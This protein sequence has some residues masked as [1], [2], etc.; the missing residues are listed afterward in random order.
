MSEQLR[1]LDERTDFRDPLRE[2]VTIRESRRA[3]RLILQV[4]PPHTL[5]VVVPKGTRPHAVEAFVREN[6]RWIEQAR[7]ELAERF[8]GERA[9]LPS[10]VD[11]AA[12]GRATSITYTSPGEGATDNA[13]A[14]TSR[15]PHVRAAGEGLIVASAD[16]S[17]RQARRMLRDWLL[18]EAR[19]HLEPWLWRE[20]ERVGVRP[21]RV[22][23][24]LQRTRW[25][26][27]SARGTI[28]LN[29]A[30]LLLEPPLVRYL[31][32]HELCH[33]RRMSHSAR[34][35]RDV[36]RFEPDYRSLD[37]ALAD[38]WTCIPLWLMQAGRDGRGAA[39]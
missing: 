21:S 1:L 35:W 31:L 25:G 32:V 33:L 12:I 20:A 23:I 3:R 18:R 36:E 30:L 14:G 34:Y 16:R 38:A 37:R 6:R 29:A 24:R 7:A 4:V 10:R 17:G 19:A 27:C 9:E 39:T 11:L 15:R 26:S 5:E 2:G 28:S 8:T 22:Q 13:A